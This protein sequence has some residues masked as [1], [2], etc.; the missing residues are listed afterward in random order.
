M[1]RP[2]LV[3]ALFVAAT[4]VL[5][6]QEASQSNRYQGTSNPPP[7]DTIVTSTT[8]Q[9]KPPAGR[10][11]TE[12][13]ARPA[14]T[15][16]DPAVN[17]AASQ[18]ARY[19]ANPAPNDTALV[20]DDGIVQVVPDPPAQ[21]GLSQRAYA[22]DPDGDI[23]HPRQSGPGEV[24][25]GTN[26]RV[27]LLQRLSTASS[28]D[29]EAFRTRVATDVLQRGQ[30]LIPA[31]AEIDGRVMHV[32]SGHAG[33]HGSM[34][35]QP[36]TVILPDGSRY[37]LYAE[38]TGTPGSRTHVGD[39]GTVLPDSRLKRDGIEYGGAVGAGAVTG[40]VLAGPVG[41][42]T[43]SLIGAGVVTTHL[44]IDHPQAVLETGTALLFTLTEPLRL[45]PA[46]AGG[47]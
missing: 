22:H 27:R 11:A 23:V 38:V 9:P 42:L 4:A 7:D 35:L 8:P 19:T 17:Y 10:V 26:I 2:I 30:V 16:V 3:C 44:L 12:S 25:E 34:R 40:A 28:E 15:S 21:G 31:G 20:G 33:G 13:Q 6:A 47:S 1:N 5:G 18:P 29:G 24:M 43:G 36:E 39:E 45:E 41:A 37:R 32:S 46:T 14:S